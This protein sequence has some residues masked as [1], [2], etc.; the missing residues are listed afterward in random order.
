[1]IPNN[2]IVGIVLVD[3]IIHNLL[4]RITRHLQDDAVAG[5]IGNAEVKCHPALLS[6][7]QVAWSTQLQ[8]LLRN[9]S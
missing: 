9:R 1:M 4:R 8:I 6:A 5:D 2:G 3:I 7:F